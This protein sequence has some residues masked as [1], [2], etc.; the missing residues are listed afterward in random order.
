MHAHEHVLGAVD[1]AAH[2]REVRSPGELLAV[3]DRD[4]LAVVRR[5]PHVR[6]PLDQLLRAPAVLDEVGDG[7]HL[8][9]VSLAVGDQIL[10]AGHRPVVVHHLAHDAGGRE[11]REPREVDGGL[12]LAGALEHAAVAC[13]QR[14]D[15]TGLHEIGRLR[16][17]MDRHLDR[18]RPVVRG[19]AR[20]HSL[21]RLDRDGERGSE[22]R[23]VVLGHLVQAEH[24]AALA[25][26]AEA[27]EAARVHRHEVDRVR[28]RELR[29]DDE[30]T[31]V[32][33]VRIVDDDDE[34]AGAD[35]LDRLV[36]GGERR[37]RRGGSHCEDGI[38]LAISRSTYLPST[39]TSRLS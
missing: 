11:T 14:K 10:D 36:D 24:V 4:E 39:S 21:A 1:V 5:Q 13:A 23:F 2:E 19:D 26:E 12:R 28:R 18:S 3:C 34:P 8:Q 20:R 9:P 27:D 15:V 31:L 33:A 7:D 30:V 37:R 35:V 17:G 6:R 25:G 38:R 29:R 16:V 32:L 22:R